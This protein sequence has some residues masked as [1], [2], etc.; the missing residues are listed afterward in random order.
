MKEQTIGALLREARV[1]KHLTLEAVEEKTMIPSSHLLALELEQF[2]LIPPNQI[3][4]Y[5]QLYGEAVDLDVGKLLT[6]YHEQTT[7]SSNRNQEN[8][9]KSISVGRRVVESPQ[10]KTTSTANTVVGS[11]S[12]R[13]KE[14]EKTNSYLP[15]VL[16]CLV[17][18]GILVFVSFVAWRQLKNDSINTSTSYSVVHENSSTTSP[19][20]SES[21]SSMSEL[22]SS[23][24]ATSLE[25]ST[26]GSGNSL[27][28]NLSNVSESIIVGISLSGADSSWV[29]VTNSEPANSGVLLSSSGT[30]SYTTTLLADTTTSLIT[31]GVTEG[32][33]VTINGQIVDTS[34]LTSTSLSYITVNI[35]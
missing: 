33:T 21:S 15:I 12:S 32:V 31:L 6:K 22:S 18:L 7:S 13:Y 16:L 17:A 9:A 11:R 28:V 10:Y 29:S 23:E 35:Q 34:A 26:E 8:M 25:I 4:S 24:E 2:K 3:E 5:L 20:T 27:T 30:T 19:I 1:A 14:K